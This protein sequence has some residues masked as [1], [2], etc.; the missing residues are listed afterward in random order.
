MTG[1]ISSLDV[2]LDVTLFAF[3]LIGLIVNRR[4]TRCLLRLFSLPAL[5]LLIHGLGVKL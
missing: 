3:V 1:P 5:P 2:S 4:S